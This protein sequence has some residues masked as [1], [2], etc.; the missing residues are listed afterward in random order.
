MNLGG[1]STAWND[2]Q[3]FAAMAAAAAA[4][5]PEQLEMLSSLLGTRLFIVKAHAILK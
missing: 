2:P 4:G 5:S 1:Q 3:Q